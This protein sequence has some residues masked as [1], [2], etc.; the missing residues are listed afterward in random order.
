M[1]NNPV[2]RG[3]RITIAG[4]DM[5]VVRGCRKMAVR[6]KRSFGFA[7]VVDSVRVGIVN[8]PKVG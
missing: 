6:E 8:R 2:I 5:A 1:D 4:S 7:E 3:A